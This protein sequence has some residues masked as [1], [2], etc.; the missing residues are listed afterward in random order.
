MYRLAKLGFSQTYT[1]FTWRNSAPELAALPDRADQPAGDRI[2]PAQ[3]VAQHAGHPARGPADRW[4]AGL[5]GAPHPG[6]H[7]VSQ[8]RHLRPCVRAWRGA[9]RATPG[10]RSTSIR[11]STSSER[12][13]C[14]RPDS[15]RP[16]DRARS[17][18]PGASTRRCSANE[19]L[20]FHPIDNDSLLAYSKTE[21]RSE[22]RAS[23]PSS[24]STSCAPSRERS[25]W[26]S[27]P[28]PAGRCAVRG[29][30]PARRRDLPLARRAQRDRARPRR[31]PRTSSGCARGFGP[32]DR[33]RPTHDRAWIFAQV[34]SRA[35]RGHRRGEPVVQGRDHLRA[36]RALV[37]RQRRRRVG[38]FR[39]PDR[40]SSTTSP[41]WASRRIWL[42]P[43]YPSPL[44]GRRLRHRR[45]HRRQPRLRHACATSRRSS[46]RPI[47]AGCG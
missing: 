17:T 33:P 12:G 16:P 2:L 11:R 19:R 8:L 39:R 34:A 47:G 21:R 46:A 14:E 35:E 26:T 10:R 6:R 28:R 9:A 44:Q 43:F 4:P 25:S 24:T 31:G 36:A 13:I 23:W 38:R 20:V 3:P 1:Y 42:L 5:R 18:A 45:L 15:P 7:A 29:A 27:R 32:S 37:L 41:T 22:R 40:A 30:R